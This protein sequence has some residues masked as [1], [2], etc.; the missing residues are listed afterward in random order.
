MNIQKSFKILSV[1]LLCSSILF[2]FWYGANEKVLE[3]NIAIENKNDIV[4]KSKWYINNEI[5]YYNFVSKDVNGNYFLHYI[6]KSVDFNT[7]ILKK[8]YQLKNK[9]FYQQRLLTLDKNFLYIEKSSLDQ[10][11]YFYTKDWTYSVVEWLDDK[12]WTCPP[13]LKDCKNTDT[14]RAKVKALNEKMKDVIWEDAYNNTTWDV[15]NWYNDMILVKDKD[16]LKTLEFRAFE[17]FLTNQS[18]KIDTQKDYIEI[19]DWK[20]YFYK[21]LFDN[22]DILRHNY[23]FTYDL[24]TNVF[25][26][27][28]MKTTTWEPINYVDNINEWNNTLINIIKV[29]WK[30]VLVENIYDN[31]YRDYFIKMYLLDDNFVWSKIFE[32]K[33]KQKKAIDTSIKDLYYDVTAWYKETY[34]NLYIYEDYKKT[35]HMFF[36]FS[37]NDQSNTLI[38]LNFNKQIIS[39]YKDISNFELYPNWEKILLKVEKKIW[40]TSYY[41]MYSIYWQ[42]SEAI[43]E[44]SNNFQFDILYEIAAIQEKWFLI[45][46]ETY[47]HH[48]YWIVKTSNVYEKTAFSPNWF[49]YMNYFFNSWNQAKKEIS[50]KLNQ[51]DI[52]NLILWAV[53]QP[54]ENVMKVDNVY[55]TDDWFFSLTVDTE[56]SL[57][58]KKTKKSTVIKKKFLLVWNIN[59]IV[60]NQWLKD[61]KEYFVSYLKDAHKFFIINKGD[62]EIS[63]I[64]PY[65]KKSVVVSNPWITWIM[66]EYNYNV[67]FKD[68]IDWYTSIENNVWVYDFKDRIFFV[69]KNKVF[70]YNILTNMIE[71]YDYSN[72]ID[73][74]I[75][76]NYLFFITQR[77]EWG[78]LVLDLYKN[79]TKI[80]SWVK[81]IDLLEY[82]QYKNHTI[83]N[84]LKNTNNTINIQKTFVIVPNLEKVLTILNAIEWII[85]KEWNLGE[86]KFYF[87][88]LFYNFYLDFVNNFDKSIIL[89]HLWYLKNSINIILWK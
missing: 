18:T 31:S 53:S 64:D 88:Q 50:F 30:R 5:Y 70:A 13:N 83:V 55:L 20:V 29:D 87:D 8:E 25:D 41:K 62:K 26:Y 81:D 27:K 6:E 77:I 65:T 71:E 2:W 76:W 73:V 16:S 61:D 4:F 35:K 36:Y 67:V 44:S 59:K 74:K 33:V 46:G 21:K 15:A 57:F 14:L 80:A 17:W 7:T 54:I 52:T 9:N 82:F 45:K 28:E 48:K 47:Y 42:N 86:Y 38:Y 72:I 66:N 49:F 39:E 11:I 1:L 32:T 19:Y 60:V 84:I 58:D 3:T 43:Y 24:A 69:S 51:K 56:K 23:I 12:V 37:K 10:K 22:K 34:S 78:T 89:N 79:T 68:K 85:I 40:E 75:M 63:L